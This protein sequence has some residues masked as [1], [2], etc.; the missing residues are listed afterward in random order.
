MYERSAKPEL[1]RVGSAA[2]PGSNWWYCEVKKTPTTDIRSIQEDKLLK[3]LFRACIRYARNFGVVM[4]EFAVDVPL[5]RVFRYPGRD[6]ILGIEFV[7]VSFEIEPEVL[8]W[9]E[10]R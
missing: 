2:Q 3:C 7:H 8:N 5:R 10:T 6:V 1:D 9:I 4:I